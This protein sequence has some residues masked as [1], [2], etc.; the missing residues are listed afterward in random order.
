MDVRRAL[1]GFMVYDDVGDDDDEGE[2]DD[3]E[4]VSL[5]CV[6]RLVEQP[7]DKG[8]RGSWEPAEAD[9]ETFSFPDALFLY[10]GVPIY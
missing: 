5:S 1:Y 4:D 9:D 8:G 2:D 3:D 10:M 7:K 6:Q